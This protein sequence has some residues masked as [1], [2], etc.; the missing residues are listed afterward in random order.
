MTKAVFAGARVGPN[1]ICPDLTK[2]T[3][4]VNWK[5]PTELQ[6]LAVFTGLTGY[7]RS[8]I[9]GYAAIAQPLTDLGRSLNI[10]KDKGKG[11]Y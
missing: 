7:F 1:G 6:N 11:A 4:I 2:L 8:L 10:S 9:K 3:A 5:Q